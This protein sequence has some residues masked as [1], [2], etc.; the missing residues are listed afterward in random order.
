M[1]QESSCS[2]CFGQGRHQGAQVCKL[3]FW[4]VSIRFYR[5]VCCVVSFF[6]HVILCV[7]VPII[8]FDLAA[9]CFLD[10]DVRLL[11]SCA[12]CVLWTLETGSVDSVDGSYDNVWYA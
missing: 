9:L 10:D 4:L 6:S 7:L 12:A 11:C 1:L 8:V 5:L 2:G 3:L